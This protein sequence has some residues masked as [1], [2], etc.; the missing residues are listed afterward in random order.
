MKVAYVVMEEIN[1]NIHLHKP[2]AIYFDGDQAN[3]D[4]VEHNK[5]DT[6][7]ENQ[8]RINDY[9]FID[10]QIPVKD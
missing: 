5:K 4:V 9:R 6:F 8:K 3:K 1:G 10:S 7:D 2:I